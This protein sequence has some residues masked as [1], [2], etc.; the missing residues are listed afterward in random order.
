MSQAIQRFWTDESGAT[1]I[2]YALLAA[3]ISVVIVGAS[4]S[5]KQAMH[6]TFTAASDKIGEVNGS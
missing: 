3:I 1:S 4:G 6:D 5:I 2:E